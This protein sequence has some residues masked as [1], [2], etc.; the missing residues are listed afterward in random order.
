MTALKKGPRDT[1]ATA[2]EMNQGPAYDSINN[3][4]KTKDNTWS[5][6]KHRQLVFLCPFLLILPREEK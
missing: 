6:G 3:F 5:P 1:D 2:S 4:I